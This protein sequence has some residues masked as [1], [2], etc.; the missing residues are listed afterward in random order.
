[1]SVLNWTGFG[2]SPTIEQAGG[3]RTGHAGVEKWIMRSADGLE[4]LGEKDECDDET[5]NYE[6]IDNGGQQKLELDAASNNDTGDAGDDD[7]EE[8]GPMHDDDIGT[9][10]TM[11]DIVCKKPSRNVHHDETGI[12]D[13]TPHARRIVRSSAMACPMSTFAYI[14]LLW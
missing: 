9:I 10:N 4:E 2:A 8:D 3:E 6:D 13:E 12:N 14:P 7:V 1:M 5:G 11:H